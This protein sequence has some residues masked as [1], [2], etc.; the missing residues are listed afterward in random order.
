MRMRLAT[1]AVLSSLPLLLVSTPHPAGAIDDDRSRRRSLQSSI[2]ELRE[3]LSET[4]KE[5]TD[6]AVELE[7]ARSGLP[8]ARDA[9]ARARAALSQSKAR[10]AALAARLAAAAREERAAARELDAVAARMVR[11]RLQAGAIARSAYQQGP[12]ADLAVYLDAESPDDFVARLAFTRSALRSGQAMF[13]QLGR[14]RA[15]L[16]AG[17]AGR[18]AK[19]DELAGLRAEAH[20][21]VAKLA[22]AERAAVGAAARVQTL[23]E[24][25]R[26]A[27]GAIS[28]E[29][30]EAERRL[31]EMEAQAR[32]LQRRL[33]ERA[34]LARLAA[35]SGRGGDKRVRHAR[36]GGGLRRPV[37]GPVTSPF[38]MRIHP[39]TRVYK[40]HDG[41]DF[42]GSCGLPVRAADDGVVL[43]AGYSGAWGN[44]IVLE[45]GVA[46]G[47]Y[48]ASSYNHLS[49][50][51]V[52]NGA[53]VRSGQVIG[54]IGSTGYS[55]GC[56]LHFSVYVDGTPVNPLRWM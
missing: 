24:R 6:A 14:D 41:T 23:V 56:H 37:G 4:S 34:R 40:L 15:E 45:H 3:S 13:E 30:A 10:E 29:K 38:G 22:T 20:A 43:E 26:S 17:G 51:A 55:T 50:Y 35:R 33:A 2:A 47:R 31:A 32:A 8:A 28:R 21:N 46:R 53:R 1:L 36:G 42:R 16:A 27:K 7:T 54:Y 48:L 9:V 12:M 11:N 44:R 52:G 49:G 19:R 18:Q 39:I 5:L 25:A